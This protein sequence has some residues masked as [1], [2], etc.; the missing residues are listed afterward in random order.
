MVVHIS[1][2]EE[3]RGDFLGSVQ[4]LTQKKDGHSMNTSQEMRVPGVSF[5]PALYFLAV[6]DNSR[7][8][9]F[10]E[11]IPKMGTTP[12]KQEMLTIR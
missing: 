3:L 8:L 1:T 2:K 6:R 4:P 10:Q 9:V 5:D 7:M 12:R 11:Y